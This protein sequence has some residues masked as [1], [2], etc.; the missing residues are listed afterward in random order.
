M[1]IGA[2]K[3]YKKK[4][5]LIG[6]ISSAVLIIAG[7][8]VFRTTRNI[9]TLEQADQHGQAFVEAINE[10]EEVHIVFLDDIVLFEWDSFVFYDLYT[11]R[12]TNRA[13]MGNPWFND[14]TMSSYLCF[15]LEDSLVARIISPPRE[16]LH[17]LNYGE[18]AVTTE[19]PLL[20]EIIPFDDFVIDEALIGMWQWELT[21]L[22]VFLVFYADG[23][24][25]EL[26]SSENTFAWTTENG[27]LIME[28]DFNGHF[29]YSI[30]DVTLTLTNVERENVNEF[31]RVD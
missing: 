4:I 21:H 16:V 17:L 13:C 6:F 18:L 30:A 28:G 29:T 15:F 7:V 10:L 24:G 20:S 23:T 19:T 14:F 2:V 22:D 3:K 5:T 27:Y 26:Q 1:E 8:F 12:D 9:R 25:T 11:M 31:Y